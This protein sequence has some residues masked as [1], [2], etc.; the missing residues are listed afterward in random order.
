MKIEFITDKE[1]SVT[2]I[3]DDGPIMV[4][5]FT[6]I[7]EAERACELASRR[8][9]LKDGLILAIDDHGR[10]GFISMVNLAFQRTQSPWFGYFAQ[11]SFAGRSWMTIALQSLESG[12]ASFLG[13]NDG[14]WA[15]LLASFGL[16]RR[17]WA[18][19][20]YDGN[21]FY[22]G[23]L[24][25]YADAELT[26]IALNQKQYTYNPNCVMTEVDWKK[27][28]ATTH[29]QDKLLFGERKLHGFG[30]KVSDPKL[31]KLFF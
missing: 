8:S 17:E 23:Y 10:K 30:N 29:P 14:K 4:M 3:S 20:N 24:R 13:F 19:Q 15:G 12:N 1:L 26:L 21:F 18:L 22:P 28:S 31:L 9:G 25:H 16:A 5:P 2:R 6:K 27:D 11:D 7:L